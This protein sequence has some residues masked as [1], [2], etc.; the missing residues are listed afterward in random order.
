MD[1]AKNAALMWASAA[2]LILAAGV[3]LTMK[4]A[5]D[6]KLDDRPL[7]IYLTGAIAASSSIS[8]STN[9][10]FFLCRVAVVL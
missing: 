3:T 7:F 8:K 6:K 10:V 9:T 2:R 1:M 5:V 4:D